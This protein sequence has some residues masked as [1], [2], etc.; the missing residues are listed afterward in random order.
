MVQVMRPRSRPRL[1]A[2]LAL[3]PACQNPQADTSPFTTTQ[4]MTSAFGSSSGGDTS[5]SSSDSGSGS[6]AGS[7]L[8]E[9]STSTSEVSTSADATTLVLDV[10]S[11]H[12]GGPLQ[13]VGCKGKID[14][15]FVI[16]RYNGMK[17]FQDQLLAA[18]P[19]FIDT[20]ESKF[21]DFDYH[22]M[23]VDGDDTWGLSTCDEKCP[24]QCV[25]DYPC[26]YTPTTCDTT[27]GAGV[28]FPAAYGATNAL[29]PIAGGRRYMAKGQADLKGTFSC[30]AR[31]GHSG[32]DLIGEALT[33]AMLLKKFDPGECNTGFLRD[34]ALLMIT[35]MSNT[36]DDPELNSKGTPGGWTAAVREAK[37]GDLN[38]VVLLNIGDTTV[39][40][41]HEDDRLC[42]MVK[43]FPYALNREFTGKDYGAYFTEATSL[44]EK[45][46][47]EFIPPG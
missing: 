27:M 22:I 19:A 32:D 29:C 28:V 44:V 12:D 37:G 8:A 14:F 41:C 33:A 4:P 16:S 21:V 2:L 15:L 39:P 42:Q 1:L 47:E 13:P 26:D 9:L 40:G 30:A 10:G 38:S 20:I 25:P 18:F 3:V 35:L 23:V 5:S 34:D 17:Y 45:A 31:L 6:H 24:E 11:D 7:T 36:Y 46:C 43:L